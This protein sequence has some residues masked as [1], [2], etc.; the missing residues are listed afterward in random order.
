MNRFVK[1][2]LLSAI[3]GSAGYWTG[4]HG[5]ILQPYYAKL[6]P[7]Y[8]KAI[9]LVPPAYLPAAFTPANAK[10]PEGAITY[11]RDPDGK[12]FYSSEAKKTEDGRDWTPVR[13]SEDVSFDEVEP[14]PKATSNAAEGGGARKIKTYRNPM[15]LPDTSPVPKKDSMGMDY[16]P[17]Y[18]GEEEDGPAFKI[19]ISKV[20]RAGVR[21][22]VVTEH[23]VTRPVRA[24]ATVQL[25]ERRVSVVSLR[26]EAYLEKVAD[27]TTGSRVKKGE[28]LMRV[29][30]PEIL[31]AAAQYRSVLGQSASL[32]DGRAPAIEGARRRLENMGLPAEA[33]AAIEKNR[34]V[35]AA[36]DWLA[37][38]DGI[39]LE[40]G[41]V[42]GMRAAPGDPMFKLAD[43]SVVWVLA[44]VAERDLGAVK[45]GD[46]AHVTLRGMPGRAFEGKVD[47]VYP[48]V[49]MA[50]RT[51][52][53]RVELA[54]ADGA[55]MPNM[56]ADV[57]I[58]TGSGA[59]VVA[60]PDSAIVDSGRRR[61][62][63]LDLGEG[64]FE[65]R[66]VKTGVRGDGF[67]E[68]REGVSVGDKVVVSANFL[69]D[70]ESNLKA[71]LQGLDQG[72]AK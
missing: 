31:A 29:Y 4:T 52:R 72:E 47:L 12:P 58:A 34:D 44:D 49:N 69:I 1:F 54:N 62:V 64:R 38:R 30:A 57:E 59:P 67:A 43:V 2:V 71:A 66:E 55:L 50:S 53:V 39:V 24:P 7:Y 35:P 40:R 17:V 21:S 27:V 11:Y 10:A 25:D 6:Q 32:G 13:A 61:I 18:E 26:F 56:F 36:I 19:A 16:L 48:Q 65:P 15:G 63:I 42:E 70:A 46:R 45:K 28:R 33:I 8:A 37:P 14:A 20:Q 5:A 23:V 68:V 22:E 9:A 3:A 60:V 41:A 51:A